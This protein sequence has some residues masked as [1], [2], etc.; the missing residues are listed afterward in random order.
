MIGG[1]PVRIA[2]R[3]DVIDDGDGVPEHLR[4]TLFLPLVSGRLDGTGLGLALAQ[5]IAHEHGG[6]IGYHS[7]P[8]R[9]VFSV[10]IP[11]ESGDA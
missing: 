4:E 2:L 8:G 10:L 3:L 11:L 6:Q 7:R 9:T 5:E 1:Q